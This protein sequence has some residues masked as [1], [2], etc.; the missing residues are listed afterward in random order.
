M[1]RVVRDEQA[2]SLRC[3]LRENVAVGVVGEP[4]IGKSTRLTQAI[5]TI[6]HVIGQSRPC[7]ATVV[8][9]PL[10]HACNTG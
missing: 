10:S 3:F 7:L 4:G 5:S 1:H 2:T 6:P 8:Y 9:A